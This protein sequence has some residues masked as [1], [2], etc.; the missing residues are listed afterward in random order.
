MVRCS[1]ICKAKWIFC[2]KNHFKWINN[3][4]FTSV[5]KCFHT[6]GV[7]DLKWDIFP[8]RTSKLWHAWVP[9]CLGAGQ[10]RWM[11]LQAVNTVEVSALLILQ[12]HHR[13]QLGCRIQECRLGL[14]HLVG[15]WLE[16]C[17]QSLVENAVFLGNELPV[18]WGQVTTMNLWTLPCRLESC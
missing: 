6:S 11:N 7:W 10:V 8:S 12:S 1:S 17:I 15:Q 3:E 4:I 16:L 13:Y 18:F 2:F 5:V 9:D 14:E